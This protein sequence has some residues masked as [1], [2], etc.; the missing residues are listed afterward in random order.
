MHYC[1]LKNKIKIKMCIY[2]K[3]KKNVL[4]LYHFYRSFTKTCIAD[5]SCNRRLINGLIY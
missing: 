3:K 1:S 2:E 5:A 4:K